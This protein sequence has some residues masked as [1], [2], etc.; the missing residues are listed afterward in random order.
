MRRPQGRGLELARKHIASCLLEL[1]GIQRSSEF[2]RSSA[3][4]SHENGKDDRT[5]ASGC[6]PIGFDATL[7]S[8]SSAPTPPR[9]I[10]TLSWEKVRGAIESRG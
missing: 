6:Q 10:S 1:E 3:G 2:L 8:R 9:A 7:N 5:T 4:K